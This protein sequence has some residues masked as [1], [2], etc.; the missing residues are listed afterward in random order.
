MTAT[1]SERPDPLTAEPGAPGSTTL[2]NRHIRIARTLRGPHDDPPWA[3]PALLAL[4]AGTALLYVWGLSASG[5]ANGFYAA[6]AQAGT[7]SWKAMF[8][9][10][11]DAGNVITVDK[12]VFFL[13]P[14]EIAGRLFGF[15]TWS[16]L[17]PQA[18]EGV[19]AVGLLAAT[20]RRTSGHAAGLLA[21]AALR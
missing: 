9:G 14:M 1:I 7:Q 16:M 15:S 19:A 4:L 5:Y 12:P 17:V 11:S 10:S 13:W 6:A 8:F 3:R 18:L 20:V 21:G 2:S